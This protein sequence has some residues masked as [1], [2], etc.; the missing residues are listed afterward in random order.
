MSETA[1]IWITNGMH[2]F[3]DVEVLAATQPGMAGQP[4]GAYSGFVDPACFVGSAAIAAERRTT[5]SSTR[6]SGA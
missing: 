1:S 6:P 3:A 4:P 5:S 2:V